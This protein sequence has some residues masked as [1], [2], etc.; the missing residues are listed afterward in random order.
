MKR[1][2]PSAIFMALSLASC[3]AVNNADNPANSGPLPASNE[4]QTSDATMRDAGS[5]LDDTASATAPA[6]PADTTAR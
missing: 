3:D 2:L 1:L 6:Q 4:P 5:M